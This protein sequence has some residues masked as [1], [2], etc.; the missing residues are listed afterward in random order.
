VKPFALAALA[1]VCSLGV[2]LSYGRFREAAWQP[3]AMAGL[4]ASCGLAWGWCC[5]QTP[6]PSRLYV[7]GLAWDAVGVLT[8]LILPAAFARLELSPPQWVGVALVAAGLLLAK[9][10]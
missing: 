9:A 7:F 10:G 1:G 8:Y 2:W 3:W 6:D 4:A 5:R